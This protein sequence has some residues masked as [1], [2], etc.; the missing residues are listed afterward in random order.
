MS[1]AEN[2][3]TWSPHTLPSQVSPHPPSSRPS[4]QSCLTVRQQ[5]KEETSH[6]NRGDGSQA[7][8]AISYSDAPSF[9]P[10]P[11]S[12]LA[13]LQPA[14]EPELLQTDEMSETSP[15]AEEQHSHRPM[16]PVLLLSQQM[17]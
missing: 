9:Q 7:H 8:H 14:A 2:M 11:P 4:L 15:P 12:Y 6:H 1:A 17:I 5:R 16:P 3:T 13:A 10:A